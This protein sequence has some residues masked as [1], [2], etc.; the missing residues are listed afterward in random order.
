MACG[1]WW[2]C[3][4]EAGGGNERTDFPYV[5]G[6][7]LPNGLAVPCLPMTVASKGDCSAHV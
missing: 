6:F 4:W 2:G 1:H 3:G 5:G 7:L